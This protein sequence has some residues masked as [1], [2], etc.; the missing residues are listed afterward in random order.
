MSW[1]GRRR[2]IYLATVILF[3]V[4]V[5]GTPVV[6]LI[7]SIKP[8][9]FDGKQNQGETAP[10]KSGPCLVLDERYITPYAVMWARSF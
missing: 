8:T 1:A 4:I 10:D 5:I 3:F 7:I 6:Y 2:F 9:C